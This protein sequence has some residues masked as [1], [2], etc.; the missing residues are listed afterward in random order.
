M[1]EILNKCKT[2][3]SMVSTNRA[4]EF[5][6]KKL[7]E[8]QMRVGMLSDE[9]MSTY[10][11]FKCNTKYESTE[12]SNH[13]KTESWQR[14]KGLSSHYHCAIRLNKLETLRDSIRTKGT[15]GVKQYN[16]VHKHG[17]SRIA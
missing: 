16:D 10:R 3:K 5:N 2:K 13:F 15:D 11:V 4:V 9:H 1:M 7:Y 17:S 8:E 14:V 12:V 6:V